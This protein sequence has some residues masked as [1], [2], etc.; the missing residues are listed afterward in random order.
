MTN[1]QLFVQS[2]FK[3]HTKKLKGKGSL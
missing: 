2:M 3:N 1:D